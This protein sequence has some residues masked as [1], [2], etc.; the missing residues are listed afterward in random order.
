MLRE[1]DHVPA[2]GGGRRSGAAPFSFGQGAKRHAFAAVP[3]EAAA[4]AGRKAG[5]LV[6]HTPCDG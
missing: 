1:D 5:Y 4:E 2:G 3:A 6:A